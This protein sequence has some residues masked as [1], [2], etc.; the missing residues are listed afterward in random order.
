M[1]TTSRSLLN[2]ILKEM[3]E[4]PTRLQHRK[5]TFKKE[6]LLISPDI[7][8]EVYKFPMLLD[9]VFQSITPDDVLFEGEMAKYNPGFKI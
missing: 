8:N 1:S 6:P 7:D 2:K 4:R 9:R 3:I 5:E